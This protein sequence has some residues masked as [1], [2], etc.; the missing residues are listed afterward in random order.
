MK[1]RQYPDARSFRVQLQISFIAVVL[2]VTTVAVIASLWIIQAELERQA[3]V[4]LEQGALATEALY[5]A[6]LR[7]LKGWVRLLAERPTLRMLLADQETGALTDYLNIFREGAALDCVLVFDGS[8]TLLAQSGIGCSSSV[9][10]SWGG[11]GIET[12]LLEV[13]GPPSLLLAVSMPVWDDGLDAP[14]GTVAIGETLDTSFVTAWIGQTGL[15]HTLFWQD[16]P[17]AT[18]LPDTPAPN[19]TRFSLADDPYYARPLILEEGLVD[20]LALSVVDLQST[21]HRLARIVIGGGLGV[22]AAGSLVGIFLARE[23]GRPLTALARV[24]DSVRKDTGTVSSAMEDVGSWRVREVIKVA[25]ALEET[26]GDLAQAL[27]E[28]RQEKAWVDRLLAAIVEGI[29]TLD[30]R[31]QITFFSRGAERITGWHSESV[32][33][34]SIDEILKLSETEEPFSVQMPPPGGHSKLPV[35]LRDGRSA[36]L[37][38]T[39]AELVQPEGDARVALVFRDVSEEETVHRLMGYFVANVAHEFRTPL[40]ALAASVELLLDQAPYLS[41]EELRELLNALH[42]S[43]LNLQTLIDN[44]L[45]SAS[46]ETGKF[47]V[48]CHPS[49]LSVIIADA[50]HTIQPLLDKH[51]QR[52]RLQVPE[53]L[54]LVDVDPRRTQQ[55]LVNLLDNASKYGPDHAQ[56]HVCVIHTGSW[57]HVEIGDEGAGIPA[58][59]QRQLFRRF[60][61]TP[62][63][64][65]GDRIGMGLGLS[66][67]KAI[68]EAQGGSV[69]VRTAPKGGATFWF[70]VPTWIG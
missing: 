21:K 70:T 46:I 67:V 28:L 8:G 37:A 59:Q 60:S 20:Q 57:I 40:S 19:M 69:G 3:W 48:H 32:L 45:E 14:L 35:T 9:I 2:M 1:R 42:L 63:A 10:G 29:V 49:A 64:E 31:G 51:D 61:R 41:P 62:A 24:V 25:R 15:A 30:A 55:V 36:V 7:T 33:N 12:T 58:A 23:M 43:V 34:R 5:E 16:E 53:S 11:D 27:A 39:S 22:V 66:V 38:M 65:E 47:R 54:P 50:L 44:L 17:L 6:H 13:T 26:R 52:L 18:T 56:I 68:V 4:Q